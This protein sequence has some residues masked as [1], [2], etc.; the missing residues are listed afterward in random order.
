VNQEYELIENHRIGNTNSSNNSY[1]GWITLG[2][3][4]SFSRCLK[5]QHPLLIANS[6]CHQ[7]PLQALSCPR[8]HFLQKP[9]NRRS[10]DRFSCSRAVI[11]DFVAKHDFN[12]NQWERWK[13]QWKCRDHTSF[14]KLLAMIS[15]KN[16]RLVCTCSYGIASL[17]LPMYR[18][19]IPFL[20]YQKMH[21]NRI[22]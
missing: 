21:G 17:N 4:E 13:H 19:L 2:E 7:E 6:I 8:K 1:I 12:L 5:V 11:L 22:K 15:V 10:I 9:M 20:N 18:T 16:S 14:F 3:F